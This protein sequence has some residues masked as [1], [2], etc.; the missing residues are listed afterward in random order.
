MSTISQARVAST[1]W[2]LPLIPEC[3]LPPTPRARAILHPTR[4]SFWPNVR[5]R[6]NPGSSQDLE[7]VV[8]ALFTDPSQ[9]W[10]MM[11]E[12]T[13]SQA[14]AALCLRM[15][16]GASPWPS[17]GEVVLDCTAGPDPPSGTSYFSP[18]PQ[19]SFGSLP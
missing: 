10:L 16:A 9:Q 18:R 8:Q 2:F 1:A 15:R 4:A 7:P 13:L 12:S 11:P 5:T 6:Q 14:G 17:E 3:L 19:F